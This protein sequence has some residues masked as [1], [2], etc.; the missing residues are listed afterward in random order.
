V[1]LQKYGTD[2]PWQ[3]GSL[4]PCD[5]H[6]VSRVAKTEVTSQVS[7]AED[8]QGVGSVARKSRKGRIDL[9][10][11]PSIENID[12]Q[13]EDAGGH[14]YFFQCV[15][16]RQRIC[17]VDQQRNASGLGNKLTQ[18]RQPFSR[19]LGEKKL[20]PV[21]LPPGRARLVTRPS[22]TGSSVTP[23]TIGIVVVAAW[24]ATAAGAKPGALT[25]SRAL[26]LTNP[27][28][29]IAGCCARAASGQ[30]VAAPPGK[31]M[32]SRRFIINFAICWNQSRPLS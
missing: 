17:G 28:T 27:I 10:A 9:A 20:M 18:E 14:L 31:V 11:G 6:H 29:G 5:R 3:W 32:N 19:K 22:L 23:K 24:A 13:P 21:A 7:I 15:L 8:E 12:L 25:A 1:A 2:A 26:P 16:G 4:Q 30:T